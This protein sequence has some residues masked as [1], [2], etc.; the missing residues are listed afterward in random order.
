MQKLFLCLALLAGL[1][2][3]EVRG[4]RKRITA[5]EKYFVIAG[6]SNAYRGDLGKNFSQW[7]LGWQ[8]TVRFNKKKRVNGGFNVGYGHVSGQINPQEINNPLYNAYFKASLINVNLDFQVNFIKTK[9]WQFYISQGFGILRYNPQDEFGEDLLGQNDTRATNES[10]GNTSIMLPTQLGLNYYLKNQFG[11]GT[12]I[13]FINPVTDYLDN[14]SQLGINTR[15]DNVLAVRLCL[16][17]P[18]KKKEA[19]K[20]F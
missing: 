14:V 13:G 15:N 9:K 7:N 11:L 8:A 2:S 4:Q 20:E 19:E 3:S 18:I 12:Q 10:Y 16:L 6:S 1:A 5:P 17:I